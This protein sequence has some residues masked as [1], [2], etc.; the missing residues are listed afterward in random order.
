MSSADNFCKQLGPR[1]GP[2]ERRSWPGSKLFD[3]LM[4]FLKEF[5]E[6]MILKKSSNDKKESKITQYGKRLRVDAYLKCFP[7][8]KAKKKM[9]KTLKTLTEFLIK[10]AIFL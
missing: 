2:T 8:C 3:I 1:S 5:F 4:V 9:L 6:K 10:I 7:F